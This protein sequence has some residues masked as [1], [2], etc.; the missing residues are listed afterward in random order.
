MQAGAH[1]LFGRALEKV[2]AEIGARCEEWERFERLREVCE[3]SPRTPEVAQLSHYLGAP[4]TLP[5]QHMRVL[6]M[7]AVH[8]DWA[9]ARDVIERWSPPAGDEELA[10]FRVCALVHVRRRGQHETAVAAA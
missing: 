7:L 9:H 3:R 5:G 6:T 4:P 10:R 8:Q 1:D 2:R